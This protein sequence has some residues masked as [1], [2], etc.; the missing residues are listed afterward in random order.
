MHNLD[1]GKS[2]NTKGNDEKDK[3]TALNYSHPKHQCTE[4]CIFW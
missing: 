2:L 1:L 3:D 4:I